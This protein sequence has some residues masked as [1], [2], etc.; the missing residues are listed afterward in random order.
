MSAPFFAFYLNFRKGCARPARRPAAES[1]PSRPSCCSQGCGAARRSGPGFYILNFAQF[2]F[3]KFKNECTGGRHFTV[4]HDS[5]FVCDFAQ[6]LLLV[7]N[8]N[9]TPIQKIRTNSCG[10]RNNSND[11]SVL[12]CSKNLVNGRCHSFL[13]IVQRFATYIFVVVILVLTLPK[14]FI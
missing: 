5:A 2:L 10:V 9:R 14:C 8:F 7:H 6:F 1:C 12:H 13:G 11:I 3:L 4:H